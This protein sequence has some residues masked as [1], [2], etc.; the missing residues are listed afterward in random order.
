M[1]AVEIFAWF[2]LIL[3]LSHFIYRVAVGRDSISVPFYR[4]NS[5]ARI[6]YVIGIALNVWFY[7]AVIQIVNG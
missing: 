5:A 2:S 7:I 1:S 6:G 3:T 4:W